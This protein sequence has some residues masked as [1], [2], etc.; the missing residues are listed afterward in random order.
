MPRTQKLSRQY[1][2]L[3]RKHVRP[4]CS[5]IGGGL[6]QAI[7]TYAR[8]PS[9]CT[10]GRLSSRTSVMDGL[11]ISGPEPLPPRAAFLILQGMYYRE[12]HVCLLCCDK[13]GVKRLVR[14]PLLGKPYVP[15]SFLP[16]RI[17]HICLFT[18]GFMAFQSH[19][20]IS[21]ATATQCF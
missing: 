9:S 4:H 10:F 2:R 18:C 13:L 3:S 11:H 16:A 5:V 6:F 20:R 14:C 15:K 19:Q 17:A 12:A 7:Q 21:F 8:R 1:D